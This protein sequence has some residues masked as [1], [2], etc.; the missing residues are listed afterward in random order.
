MIVFVIG[1]RLIPI[2]QCRRI[3]YANVDDTPVK[4]DDTQAVELLERST[5]TSIEQK[6]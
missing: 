3:R 5:Q 1:G 2:W 4:R 6:E